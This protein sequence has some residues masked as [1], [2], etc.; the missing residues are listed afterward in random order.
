MTQLEQLQR[1]VQ[2]LGIVPHQTVT[3]IDVEWSGAN[4]VTV[5]YRRSDGK[6]G[7]ILL[8][9]ENESELEVVQDQ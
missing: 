5:V 6:V 4:A 9:R 7:D 1:G 3:L 2:L 8:F